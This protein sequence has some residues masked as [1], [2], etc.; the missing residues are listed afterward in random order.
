MTIQLT[1]LL[2]QS[3]R[4]A[5]SLV[6]K[7]AEMEQQRNG[8]LPQSPFMLMGPPSPFPSMNGHGGYPGNMSPMV[9]GSPYGMGFPSPGM[10]GPSRNNMAHPQMYPSPLLHPNAHAHLLNAANGNMNMLNV[11]G[12]GLHLQNT[13]PFRRTSTSDSSNDVFAGPLTPGIP[14]STP[15]PYPYELGHGFPSG[16]M[17]MPMSTSM[18]GPASTDERGSPLESMTR[19]ERRTSIEASVLK[20]K[21]GH[22]IS[23]QEGEEG[24]EAIEEEKE[25]DVVGLGMGEVDASGNKEHRQEGQQEESVNDQDDV[26]GQQEEH[27][28]NGENGLESQEDELR[29]SLSPPQHF[30]VTNSGSGSNFTSN[31]PTPSPQSRLLTPSHLHNATLAEEIGSSRSSSAFDND[32]RRVS[33]D[34]TPLSASISV[35]E[36]NGL[37]PFSTNGGNGTRPATPVNQ[38]WASDL[39]DDQLAQRKQLAI[40]REQK[41]AADAKRREKGNKVKEKVEPGGKV[42]TKT[43]TKTEAEIEV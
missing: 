36:V 3:R 16:N 39:T 6:Q 12:N 31:P 41:L 28:G 13:S 34:E 21:P 27:N 42:D 17:P 26:P 25:G 5:A 24:P 23:P 33:H 20:K 10:G 38:L 30:G 15:S 1:K 2:D 8:G 4:H 29:S 43:E 7:L 40:M 22:F 11:N 35:N 32:K 14:S 19:E 9:P 18:S 37:Q